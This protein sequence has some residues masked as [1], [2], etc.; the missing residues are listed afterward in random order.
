MSL[1]VPK[2]FLHTS[3]VKIGICTI[4]D[5]LEHLLTVGAMVSNLS[6]FFTSKKSRNMKSINLIKVSL[7]EIQQEVMK[8]VNGMTFHLLHKVKDSRTITPT[9]CSRTG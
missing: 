2:D 6:Q 4:Q 3:L 1:R 8:E 7:P 5:P 9:K